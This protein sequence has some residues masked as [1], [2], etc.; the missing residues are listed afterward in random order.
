MRS[1]KLECKRY[2]LHKLLHAVQ[3]LLTVQYLISPKLNAQYISFALWNL[4]SEEKEKTTESRMTIFLKN[5][6]TSYYRTLKSTVYSLEV[7]MKKT[8][9]FRTYENKGPLQ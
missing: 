7:K 2:R 6:K 3:N 5:H 4:I 1:C 8:E 9:M